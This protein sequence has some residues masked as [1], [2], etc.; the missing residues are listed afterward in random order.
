MPPGSGFRAFPVHRAETRIRRRELFEH[1]A[2]A[3]D[4]VLNRDQV[5][6]VAGNVG[7]CAQ[8]CHAGQIARADE[9]SKL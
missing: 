6:L 5:D 3:A 2:D 4:L 9:R 7:D 8:R 1:P